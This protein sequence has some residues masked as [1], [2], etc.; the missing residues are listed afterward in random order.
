MDLGERCVS[1][2]MNFSLAE[3][4]FSVSTKPKNVPRLTTLSYLPLS[5]VLRNRPVYLSAIDEWPLC[6]KRKLTQECR[7]VEN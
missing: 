6:E 7:A 5:F 2:E 3:S 1:H 4:M